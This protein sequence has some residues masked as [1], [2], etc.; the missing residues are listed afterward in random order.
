MTKI[1]IDS[2]I[3]L[4]DEKNDLVFKRGLFLDVKNNFEGASELINECSIEDQETLE[5][6]EET[7]N[8]NFPKLSKLKKIVLFLINLKINFI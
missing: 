8:E 3:K 7:Y 1:K 5:L 4:I 6:V 2:K